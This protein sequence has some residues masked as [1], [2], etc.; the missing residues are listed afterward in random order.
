MD[1][2]KFF[3]IK[4]DF[5]INDNFADANFYIKIGSDYKLFLTEG[6]SNLD[7]LIKLRERDCLDIYVDKCTLI[8]Y[9]KFKE[10]ILKTELSGI[11]DNQKCLEQFKN[12]CELLKDFFTG[13]T[14]DVDKVNFIQGIG[15]QSIQIIERTAFLPTLFKNFKKD[16]P[17]YFIE[18]QMIS[19]FSIFSLKYFDTIPQEHLDKFSVAILLT[20]ILLKPEEIPKTYVSFDPKMPKEILNHPL[21]ILKILPNEPYFQSTTIL[22]LIKNH[23]ERPDGTGYP[24][25][26]SFT[27]FDLFHCSYYIAEQIVAKL[28]KKDLK[29]NALKEVYKEVYEENKKYATPNFKRCFANYDKFILEESK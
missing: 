2:S 20:D 29:L 17:D 10:E 13:V 19:F 12:N 24:N 3:A 5:L 4:L 18:K 7:R 11:K 28:I 16:S 26:I 27:R 22:N 15:K 8:K 9:M 1:K 6:E 23:H 21:N 25:K 14:S